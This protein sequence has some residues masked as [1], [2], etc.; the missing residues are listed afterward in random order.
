VVTTLWARR[1]VIRPIRIFGALAIAGTIAAALTFARVSIPITFLATTAC[2]ALAFAL[3]G[4]PTSRSIGPTPRRMLWLL[5]AALIVA[6]M[7]HNLALKVGVFVS[8]GASGGEILLDAVFGV[9]ALLLLISL[10]YVVRGM[11][12]DPGDRLLAG[13]LAALV[14]P[15]PANA[16]GLMQMGAQALASQPMWWVYPYSLL[17]GAALARANGN[18][19]RP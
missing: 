17:L 2:L 7:A 14:I 6:A 11:L 9:E 16:V 18:L 10:V 1:H 19:R 12:A 5:A 3:N 8:I 15:L 13:A 4:R